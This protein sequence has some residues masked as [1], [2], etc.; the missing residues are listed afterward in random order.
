MTVIVD[1]PV[2]ALTRLTAN[3][4]VTTL[5]SALMMVLLSAGTAAGQQLLNTRPSPVW[6]QPGE[7]PQFRGPQGEGFSDHQQVPVRWSE[8][9]HVVWK[10]ALHDRGWSSP[11]AWDEST[12]WCTTA[13]PDGQRMALLGVDFATGRLV[14]DIHLFD[15]DKVSEIHATNSYASCTPTVDEDHVYAHFGSYGTACV[16]SRTGQVVWQRRDLPCEHFRGPGSSPILFD[17]LLIIHYD[18]FDYQYV[19]A[20]D[21]RTGRTVWKRDRDIEYGTDDGDLKKAFCTPLLIRVGDGWQL[22]SPTSKATLALDPR[23]G[24]EIWRVRYDTFSATARP[25]FRGDLL[26]V[27]TGFSKAD[28]WAVRPDGRGDVTDSHVV[29]KQTQSVGSKPSAVLY[30]GLLFG[31]H[32]AGVASCWEADTGKRVWAERLGGNYSASLLRAGDRVY[33]FNEEGTTTVVQ[34]DR[35]YQLL[36]TNQLDDGC[37]S[38]PAVI[39]DSLIVRTKTHLYRLAD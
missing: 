2:R 1:W 27:N 26:F 38:S 33:F 6:T 39:G 17:D 8:T 34:A 32:D 18:G 20:L 19:V 4:A 29:W 5:R 12:V 28:L 9:E 37:M 31:V 21:K 13:T 7:W 15:N 11:V 3:A 23:T 24:E 22:I 16:D 14:H 25:L 36:A 30:N 10:T 35:Q